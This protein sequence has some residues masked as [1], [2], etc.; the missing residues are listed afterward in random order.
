MVLSTRFKTSWLRKDR[1]AQC[2]HVR[3]VVPRTRDAKR[4]LVEC[5]ET[6]AGRGSRRFPSTA[7]ARTHDYSLEFCFSVV[8]DAARLDRHWRDTRLIV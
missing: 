1:G 6:L 4:V 7:A 3:R 5:P 2:P 8:P